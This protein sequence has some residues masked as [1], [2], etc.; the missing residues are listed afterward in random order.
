ME[1]L[2]DLRQVDHGG[3]RP[4]LVLRV[5]ELDVDGL[6]LLL[7]L[8]RVEH[9]AGVDRADIARELTDGVG[10]EPARVDGP[11]ACCEHVHLA[12]R[13]LLG[14]G[15]RRRDLARVT[16]FDVVVGLRLLLEAVAVLGRGGVEE[17]GDVRETVVLDRGAAGDRD[18]LGLFHRGVEGDGMVLQDDGVEVV[19]VV[20]AVA[21]ELEDVVHR[22]PLVKGAVCHE[23]EEDDPHQLLLFEAAVLAQLDD[24]GSE[25]GE[26]GF[27]RVRAFEQPVQGLSTGVILERLPHLLQLEDLRH[28][29]DRLHASGLGRRHLRRLL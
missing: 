19:V 6:D 10:N 8:R 4:P 25:L 9:G 18:L 29:V 28:V 23:H 11:A 22:Q 12:G 7:S 27:A 26:V 20:R 16:A 15:V 14:P 1:R 24:E 5:P 13:G 2:A 21:A 3:R 17:P